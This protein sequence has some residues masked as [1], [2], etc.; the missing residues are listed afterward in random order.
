[1]ELLITGGYPRDNHARCKEGFRYAEAFVS[2]L[3]WEKEEFV[4]ELRYKSPLEYSSESLTQQ[5]KTGTVI[6]DELIV[7]SNIEILFIDIDT[8]KINRVITKPSFTDLHHVTVHD[9]NLY[10]A[11]T[12]VESVQILDFEGDIL[13]EYPQV[14]DATWKQ[15]GESPDLRLV[16]STKP[17]F[18]HLNFVFFLD[19]EPWITRFQKRDAVSLF[20][21]GK[22]IDL[23]ISEGRPHDGHIVGDFIYFTL[24]DGHIV[25]VN[26]NTLKRE[27]VIDLNEICN[28]KLQLGW[29]RG[30]E[31]VGDQ[32][33]VGFSRLRRSKI[34]EYGAWIIQGKQKQPARIAQYDMTK[35]E[36]VKEVEL[37]DK[38]GAIFTVRHIND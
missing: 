19:G 17:H 24:T 10:V 33:Y 8:F 2:V 35:K 6:G 30:I 21:H 20:D 1:V 31:I 18:V 36:L 9:D 23:A 5:F 38:G 14:E 29:C 12:G 28:N 15:F 34:V 32:A 22:R 4:R 3:D 26:K 7:P 37:G 13:N 25:V 11:N 16:A 27:D